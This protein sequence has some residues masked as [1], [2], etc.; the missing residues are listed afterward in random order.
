MLKSSAAPFSKNESGRID[1]GAFSRESIVVS[2]PC[3]VR[4]SMNPPPP[5]PLENGSVTPSTAAAATAASTAFPPR[6]STSRAALVATLSTVAAAPPVPSAV[7]CF[8]CWYGFAATTE[9]VARTAP[10]PSSARRCRLG[11]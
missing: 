5:M 8:M 1:A 2:S 9:G 3:G 6:R 11:I 7:G 4:M 10:I